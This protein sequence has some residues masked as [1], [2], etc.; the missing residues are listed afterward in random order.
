MSITVFKG[1]VDSQIKNK[2]LPL[3]ISN[4][5][6]A[7]L[8]H[9]LADYIAQYFG[10]ADPATQPYLRLNNITGGTRDTRLY[11][12][13]NQSS[14]ISTGNGLASYI[15]GNSTLGALVGR[16]IVAKG[17][18]VLAEGVAS[19]AQIAANAASGYAPFISFHENNTARGAIGFRP[20]GTSMQLRVG[21][22]AD[23]DT[24]VVAQ[25][26]FPNGRIGINTTVDS[27]HQVNFNGTTRFVGHMTLDQASVLY[28][29]TTNGYINGNGGGEVSL[30]GGNAVRLQDAN[31]IA[32]TATAPPWGIVSAAIPRALNVGANA[33]APAS[34]IL[35]AESITKGFLP[36]RMTTTQRNNI[37]SPDEGLM[38]YDT[39]LKKSMTYDGTTWQAHY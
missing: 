11:S 31:G 21:G 24:G 15:G 6:H 20:G 25:N 30:Y 29:G 39:T 7:D 27:G 8:L 34:A 5:E 17:G 28:L 35:S 2:T 22:S 37:T 14:L 36:P 32:F 3:S 38:V 9:G 13:S 16:H 33:S 4:I 1:L 18:I 12:V 10:E 23:M 19:N 26:I